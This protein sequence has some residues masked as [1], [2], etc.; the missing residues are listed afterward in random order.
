[1]GYPETKIQQKNPDDISYTDDNINPS[2]D[3]EN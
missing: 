3:P 2:D 1:M